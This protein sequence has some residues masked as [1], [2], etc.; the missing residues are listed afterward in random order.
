MV[1]NDPEHQRGPGAQWPDNPGKQR[2]DQK[3]N[4]MKTTFR[5]L[6]VPWPLVIFLLLPAL[7]HAETPV[8]AW[9]QRYNG[10][11]NGLD[12][13]K[14]V[15][16][17]G[18]NNVIVT[19]YSLGNGSGNDYATL[20]YSSAG[21]PL[22]TNRYNGPGNSDDYA[23]AMAVDGSNN[24]IV[25]GY[26]T[27]T[28]TNYDYATIKYS[29]A[30]VP[31]WT[32]RY[33]GP[34]NGDDYAFAVA[35]DGS[36]NVIVTGYSDSGEYNYDYATIKY[37][38]AGVPL[39]TDRY[40]GPGNDT[41]YATAVA[42]DGSNNVIVTGYSIGSGTAGD[43][44]TLKYSSAGVPLWT[45]RYNGP[46]NGDDGAT[47]MAVDGNN[48]VIVTGYSD[49]NGYGTNYDYATLKYSSAGVPLWTNRYNGPGNSDDGAT[50]V[51]VDGSNNV[52]VTGY[53]Y[54][55]TDYDYATIK[56]SS[57]GVPLW[58]NRY[59]GPGTSNDRA[60]AVAMDSSNNVIVTGYSSNGTNYD[61]A[62]IK[63]SGAGVP[64]WTNR[65]NGPGNGDDEAS[66]VAVDHSGNV[67]VTGYSY[68]S[69]SG[70]DYA[71]IK[72]VF[73]LVITDF[74]LTNGTFQ[75]RVDNLQPGALEIQASTNLSTNLT[76]WVPLLTNTTPT[77]G[78][79][80]AD[81]DAGDYPS[82]FY[83]AFQSP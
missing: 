72:Y 14:A 44:A 6:T 12:E 82:R 48:N 8:Q 68:G 32:N 36:N 78:L 16:A 11:G 49:V 31:L 58:T 42:V 61:Y 23:W 29:S 74:K 60:T 13:A 4:P 63:Y 5:E 62:T 37:S 66:A 47:A 21:V 51:A 10:P 65:Y 20:K 9:V 75:V 57:A 79:F 64:L 26:S 70:D 67:I 76:G 40:N 53:S 27:G 38:S 59:N 34:G 54:N 83:R 52:I 2:F 73:P 24:V 39:W 43:Y 77:N 33:N 56:Y 69:G 25:T 30:G 22:W 50:A 80:Y 17:D 71:T 7:T 81:P 15:A 19:G 41:D 3:D 55:G 1:R 45:N 35:V 28:A 18:S 46:G